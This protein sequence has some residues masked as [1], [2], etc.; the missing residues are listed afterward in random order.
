[1]ESIRLTGPGRNGVELLV[2][3]SH[4]SNLDCHPD[5]NRR[6]AWALE[7]LEQLGARISPRNALDARLSGFVHANS[8]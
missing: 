8:K 5:T 6:R 3:W 4:A 1:M 2:T 7:Y